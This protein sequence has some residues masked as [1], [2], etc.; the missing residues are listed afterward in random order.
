M[1]EGL[2][3]LKVRNA[4]ASSVFHFYEIVVVLLIISVYL[5]LIH[6][7]TKYAGFSR[8][9]TFCECCWKKIGEKEF[10]LN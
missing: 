1:R 4:E 9:W 6:R 7:P 3:C 10:I 8:S 2:V 5:V